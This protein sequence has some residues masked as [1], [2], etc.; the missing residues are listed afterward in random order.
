[1]MKGAI[2]FFFRRV[3]DFKQFENRSRLSQKYSTVES[4]KNLR[5]IPEVLQIPPN[6]HQEKKNYF[7]TSR[8]KEIE[9]STNLIIR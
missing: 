2:V 7:E 6:N 3:C 4:K 9:I 5:Q 1:M 8:D